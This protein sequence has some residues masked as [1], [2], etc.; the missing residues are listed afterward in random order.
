LTETARL[1]GFA[2]RFVALAIDVVVVNL[3]A[4]LIGVGVAIVGQV[5]SLDAGGDFSLTDAVLAGAAWLALAGAYLLV[6][7]TLS[8]QTPGMAFMGLRVIAS[9]GG[10]VSWP[11]AVR[12]LAG[13]YVCVLTLGAGFLLILVD[14]RRRGLHDR[15]AGTLVIHDPGAG[16]GGR[17]WGAPRT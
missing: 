11:R 7:W 5:L 8:G 16:R 3:I 14:E 13:M 4:V 6:F 2:T 17:P 9:S 1:A 10:R 12:R 15:M